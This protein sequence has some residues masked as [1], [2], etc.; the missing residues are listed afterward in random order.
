VDHRC[1][2]TAH[3][4][5]IHAGVLRTAGGTRTLACHAAGS[6]PK[7]RRAHVRSVPSNESGGSSNSGGGWIA[8]D[9]IPRRAW[10]APN[11]SRLGVPLPVYL[12]GVAV[13]RD[14]GLASLRQAQVLGEPWPGGAVGCACNVCRCP[15]RENVPAVRA[16]ARAHVEEVVGGRQQVQVVV[17]DDD[18]GPSIQQRCRSASAAG[19]WSI[20]STSGR[21]AWVSR[22]RL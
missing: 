13:R 18:G 5:V 11:G 15:G 19:R 20:R 1:R 4:V 7:K 9:L 21:W 22:R 12:S 14:T 10:A 3:G 8:A 16:A 17:D 6:R 2:D